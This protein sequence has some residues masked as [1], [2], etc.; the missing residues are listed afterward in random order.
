MGNSFT[1]PV[2]QLD[3]FSV[4]K[5]PLTSQLLYIRSEDNA[6]QFIV[7]QSDKDEDFIYYFPTGIVEDK[8]VNGV[9][10]FNM[11]YG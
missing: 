2:W 7:D 6:V 4:I 1:D 3:E 10:D 11:K 8:S 5:N 9:W